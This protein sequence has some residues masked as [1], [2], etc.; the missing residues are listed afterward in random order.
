HQREFYM[1]GLQIT[2]FL[3]GMTI[4]VIGYRKNNRN[5]LLLSALVL[6]AAGALQEFI[7]GFI[8]GAL[9]Y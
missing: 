3:I 8:A 4:L 2:L 5:V 6:L 7:S 1:Y 9:A